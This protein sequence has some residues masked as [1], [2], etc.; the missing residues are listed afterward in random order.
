MAL[1]G[2]RA[3]AA[4]YGRIDVPDPGEPLVLATDGA[5]GGPRG[6]LGWLCT[7]GQY[8]FR[9]YPHPQ[10]VVGDSR[11]V[12]ELRAVYEGLRH[13]TGTVRLLVDSNEAVMYLQRWRRGELVYPDGYTTLRPRATLVSL[14]RLVSN[15]N[16][17]LDVR[18]VTAGHVLNKTAD[19][20]A[21]LA[22]RTPKNFAKDQ[23]RGLAAVYVARSLAEYRKSPAGAGSVSRSVRC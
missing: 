9:S 11:A 14:A 4:C 21:R 7:D 20:L 19:S 13:V 8:G 6:A 5:G 15:R 17:S 22:I 12:N 23:A 10:V 16:D 3:A 2:D 1:K 18:L